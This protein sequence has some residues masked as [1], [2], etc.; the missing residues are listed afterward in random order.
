[1]TS[2]HLADRILLALED[3]FVNAAV[4]SGAG[5]ASDWADYKRRVGEIQG[6]TK[7]KDI[8]ERE[9]KA[10]GEDDDNEDF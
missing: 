2:K 1:M 8:V 10:L 3:A 5:A 4:T 7:A 9:L 6:L